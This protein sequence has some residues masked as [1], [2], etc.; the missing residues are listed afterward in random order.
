MEKSPGLKSNSSINGPFFSELLNYQRDM[1][2]LIDQTE[3]DIISGVWPL[4][5]ICES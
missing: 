2:L 4:K 3:K 1:K 5:L